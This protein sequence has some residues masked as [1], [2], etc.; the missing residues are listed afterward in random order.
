[1]SELNQVLP[2]LSVLQV[3]NLL[4]EL[5]AERR[6]HSVGRTRGGLWLP[7]AGPS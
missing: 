3:Q 5:K 7:G 4:R 1:L 6:A 2:G